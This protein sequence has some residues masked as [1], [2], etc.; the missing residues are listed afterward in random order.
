MNITSAW[1]RDAQRTVHREKAYSPHFLLFI[2]FWI[3]RIKALFYFLFHDNQYAFSPWWDFPKEYKSLLELPCQ[4]M[5]VVWKKHF[6]ESFGIIFIL[7]HS[8]FYDPWRNG[9]LYFFLFS[10]SIKHVVSIQHS[11]QMNASPSLLFSL[12]LV[13]T[14]RV[15]VTSF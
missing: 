4:I 14:T 10:I 9:S 8:F 5:T 6:C 11:G 7:Y 1:G 12:N 3:M 15:P 2:M 13:E